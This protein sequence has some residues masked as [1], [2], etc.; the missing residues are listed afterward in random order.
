MMKIH[1]DKIAFVHLIALSLLMPG[2]VAQTISPQRKSDV[3][4]QMNL[5]DWR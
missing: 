1:I 3:L 4:N 2:M 5:T